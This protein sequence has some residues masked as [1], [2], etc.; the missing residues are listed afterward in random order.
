MTTSQRS[1]EK[2][3]CFVRHEVESEMINLASEGFGKNNGV[4]K[5]NINKII[6][7]DVSDVATTAM[8]VSTNAFRDGIPRGKTNCVFCEKSHLSFD[9]LAQKMS[10]NEKKQILF[11]KGI[12]FKYLNYGHTSIKCRV[13]LKC[14]KYNKQHAT[15]MCSDKKEIY[16]FKANESSKVANNLSNNNYNDKVYLQTICVEIVGQANKI[17]VRDS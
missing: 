13:K 9:F 16:S 17:R 5:R 1:L 11:K 3:M 8:L 7:A 15:L 10:Y 14:L 2:S 6:I 12:C 4:L